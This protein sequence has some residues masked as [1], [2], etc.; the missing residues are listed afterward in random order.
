MTGKM[1]HLPEKDLS[2]A[3]DI[4]DGNF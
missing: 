2:V 3:A 4:Y 1:Q